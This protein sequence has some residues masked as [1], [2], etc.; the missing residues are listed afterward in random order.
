MKV[1]ANKVPSYILYITQGK[2]YD[3]TS[4]KDDSYCA[5]IEDDDGEELCI[6]I[7]FPCSHL[8]GKSWTVV[9]D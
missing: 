4:I 1:K 7:G 5:L 9:E 8:N 3:V 2:E 6:I